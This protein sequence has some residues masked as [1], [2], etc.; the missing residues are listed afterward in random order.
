MSEKVFQGK[1]SR[2]KSGI[3]EQGESEVGHTEKSDESL[4]RGNHL[5]CPVEMMMLGLRHQNV[6]P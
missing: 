4:L 3:P 1:L 6:N 5:R 2:A